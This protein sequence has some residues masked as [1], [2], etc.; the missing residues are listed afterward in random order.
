MLRLL[1]RLREGTMSFR[2]LQVKARS[3]ACF[4]KD[5]YKKK[6]NSYVYSI[7]IIYLPTLITA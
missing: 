1:E 3:D 7:C 5:A 4:A 2:Y 6:G